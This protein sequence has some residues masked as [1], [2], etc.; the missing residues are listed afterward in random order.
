MRS[1]NGARVVARRLI[2][3]AALLTLASALPMTAAAPAVASTTSDGAFVTHVYR[4]FLFRDP[5]ADELTW[6]TTAMA[7]GTSRLSVASGVLH[8]DEFANFWVIG[9]S[10][11]YLDDFDM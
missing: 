9:V 3:L 7:S 8:G 6:W 5:T 2:L 4:D 1:P 11:L 10:L